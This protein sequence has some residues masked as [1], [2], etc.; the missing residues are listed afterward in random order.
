MSIYRHEG[1]ADCYI[2]RGVVCPLAVT[3]VAINAIPLLGLLENR[4]LSGILSGITLEAF[5]QETE[6]LSVL[7]NIPLEATL[8][9]IPIAS[10]LNDEEMKA[11]LENIPLEAKN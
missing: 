9:N 4:G 5:M 10:D 11:L 8:E 7:E 1:N 2:S 6:L 3:D